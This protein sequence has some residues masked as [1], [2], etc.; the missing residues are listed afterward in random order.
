LKYLAYAY[1]DLWSASKNDPSPGPGRV[2]KSPVL[3]GLNLF[4]SFIEFISVVE[5]YA[6]IGQY[7]S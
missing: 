5:K 4:L 2:L 6:N 7:I 3:I 1:R